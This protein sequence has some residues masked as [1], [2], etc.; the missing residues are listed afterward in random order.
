[1]ECTE[2]TVNVIKSVR[3]DL[4]KDFYELEARRK[5]VKSTI[6]QPYEE[7][8]K[9][10]RQYISNKYKD[11]DLLLKDKINSIEND[12]KERKRKDLELYFNE[13]ALTK[14]IGFELKLSDANIN[15]RLSDS[16]KSLMSQARSFIDKVA[17]DVDLIRQQQYATEI[18]LE[19]RRTFNSVKAIAV[20]N[21]WHIQLEQIEKRKQEI[22]DS[23]VREVVKAVVESPEEE[24]T[25][26][27]TVTA[28]ISKLKELKNFLIEGKYKFT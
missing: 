8:E 20:I 27:F 24:R 9:A 19:Y 21:N 1:M 12:I 22:R 11:T 18:L 26:M 2:E 15:V 4:N 10:Y 25:T 14:D 28:T 17:D 23:K 3:A 6:L 5:A 13:Y 7:F 16:M